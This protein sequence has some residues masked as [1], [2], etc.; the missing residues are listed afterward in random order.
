MQLRIASSGVKL[1]IEASNHATASAMFYQLSY[2]DCRLYHPNVSYMLFIQLLYYCNVTDICYFYPD[3][4][5]LFS[6]VA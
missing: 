4:L 5:A 1:G 6:V 2:W 3:Y